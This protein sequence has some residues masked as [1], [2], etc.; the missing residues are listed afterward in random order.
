MYIT[1]FGNGTIGISFFYDDTEADYYFPNPFNSVNN[2]NSLTAMYVQEAPA[3]GPIVNELPLISSPTN[4]NVFYFGFIFLSGQQPWY[5]PTNDP[6]PDN[7]IYANLLQ[8]TQ[9]TLDNFVTSTV[10]NGGGND[11]AWWYTFDF[12]YSGYV[13]YGF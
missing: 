13:T 8:I 6:P 7:A 3:N 1:N 2:G 11:G 5:G 10:I 4:L 9:S 12:N